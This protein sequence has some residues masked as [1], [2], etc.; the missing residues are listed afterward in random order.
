[1]PIK[2]IAFDADD[3]LW[4]NEPF[5]REAEEKFASLLEDFMPEHAIMKELYRTEIE[6]LQLYGYG[7]KGFM[8]SLIETA[9]RISDHKVP[10][11]LIDK[12]L[13]IGK[14]ML[15][16][17][18]ELLPGVEEV[19]Q[20]LNGDFRIVM[21]T[22]GDLVDQER[23]LKK[24]GLEKHFHHIEIMSE[25][26]VADYEKLIRHLDIQPS[27]FMMLGNSLKSDILPV[28]ELGGYGIHI[29]FHTTWIHEQVDHTVE[30]ERFFTVD[31]IAEASELLKK[32]GTN[33]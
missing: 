28:L 33:S 15:A 4:V 1:M 9:L 6:N 17:P 24:S 5:F 31:N 27:E 2:V 22:K 20:A 13:A 30:H 29:P 14:E 3:T 25:K 21:A 7:I 16:K 10:I 12:I 8:L 18:V 26:R 11:T 23:K 19:L 32:M